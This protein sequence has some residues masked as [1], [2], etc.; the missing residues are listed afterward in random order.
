MAI[1]IMLTTLTDEGRKWVRKYGKFRREIEKAVFNITFTF[2]VFYLIFI[3]LP[4][5]GPRVQLPGA[6]GMPRPGYIFAP[7][8]EWLFNT[9]GIAGA[10][11]PSSHCGVATVVFLMSAKYIPRAAPVVAIFVVLLFCAT[12]YGRFHY[13]VD[14]FYG[15]GLGAI[16]YILAP[17]V[18]QALIKSG[19]TGPNGLPEK[20]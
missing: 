3:I 13:A 14:V 6:I 10:A 16:C 20:D 15:I 7:F 2:V 9:M 4:V 11:F 17:Y 18:R 1:Y 5:Q 8:F 12:V 19:F